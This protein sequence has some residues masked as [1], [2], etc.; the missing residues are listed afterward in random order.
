MISFVLRMLAV[1]LLAS[2]ALAAPGDPVG[3][4]FQ[5]N[6]STTS[7]QWETSVAPDGGGG[8]VVVWAGYGG[9]DTSGLGILAQLYDALGSTVGPEFQVNTYTTGIQRQPAVGADPG[10]GFVVVW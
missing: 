7:S 6:T 3:I 9:T 5:V 8:F 1:A 4:E 2:V 10:G